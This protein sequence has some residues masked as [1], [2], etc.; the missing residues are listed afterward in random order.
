MISIPIAV[1]MIRQFKE[2]ESLTKRKKGYTQC[3]ISLGCYSTYST[4]CNDTVLYSTTLIVHG[5]MIQSYIVYSTLCLMIH[6]TMISIYLIH[7]VIVQV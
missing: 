1:V 7:G 3:L 2:R 6:D 4:W 5:V